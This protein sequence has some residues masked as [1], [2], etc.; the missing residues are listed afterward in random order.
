[1]TD[2]GGCWLAVI[3]CIVFLEV[4]R[5]SYT[6]FKG[7]RGSQNLER[8]K[9]WG[10]LPCSGARPRK[11]DARLTSYFM[12]RGWGAQS[13][14]SSSLRWLRDQKGSPAVEGTTAE[15]WE[16]PGLTKSTCQELN[17]KNWFREFLSFCKEALNT[18]TWVHLWPK[19]IPLTLKQHIS[20]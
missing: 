3:V 15:A 1:M 4:L 5:T 10:N 16:K 6:W 12:W 11:S 17:T 19:A 20:P 7:G 9:V 2:M 18:C 8:T 13:A 14:S